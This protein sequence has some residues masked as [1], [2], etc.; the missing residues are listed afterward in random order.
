MGVEEPLYFLSA[1]IAITLTIKLRI[2]M[3]PKYN[4][5]IDD[6][7]SYTIVK[8]WHKV[9]FKSLCI[10][11]GA[12]LV[13]NLTGDRHSIIFAVSSEV[14]DSRTLKKLVLLTFN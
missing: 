12:F 8:K 6:G 10:A 11:D 4:D 14:V 5:F 7:V 13:L 1:C 2:S 9:D 3:N